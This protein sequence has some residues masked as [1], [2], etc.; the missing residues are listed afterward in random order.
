MSNKKKDEEIDDVDD[1]DDVDDI[2]DEDIQSVYP[3][4]V[5]EE[6]EDVE[7][8]ELEAEP[9]EEPVEVEEGLEEDLEEDFEFAIEEE[10]EGPTYKFVD[11]EI[12]HKGANN[13]NITV[14]GQSHGF[15]NLFTKHLLN[16][17]SVKLAA[18]KKTDI[19]EPK[20]F[21]RLN[22]GHKIKEALRAG[23][24]SLQ[25]EINEAKK[26]FSSLM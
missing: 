25:E 2:V 18:Y 23:I 10:L 1:V 5:S 12:S 15:L 6:E 17:D 14:K 24:N 3:K 16:L 11:L 7:I 21:I 26:A 8:E 19:E 9:I 4:F 13:Y 20:L 22:E